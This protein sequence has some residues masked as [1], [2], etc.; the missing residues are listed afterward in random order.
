MAR[1][2]KILKEEQDEGK[3]ISK[4]NV[5]KMQNHQKKWQSHGDLR[6]S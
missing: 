1:Q 2:R 5:R 6:K 4:T 3:T